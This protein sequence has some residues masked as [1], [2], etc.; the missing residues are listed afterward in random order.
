[1]AVFLSTFINKLDRKGRISVPATFRAALQD[2]SY[3]GIVVF[4]AVKHPAIE[5]AAMDRMEELS[6][7]IDQ[8]AEMSDER[9]ALSALLADARQLP[10][11]TEGRIMLPADLAKHA[12]IEGSAA[13][14]GRGPTFQLW[15]PEALKR[16][17]DEM[18]TRIRTLGLTLPPRET[19]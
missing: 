10:F 6:R 17:Q 8:L 7:R 4:R 5:A 11:D 18:R 2:S 14:V 3:A 12:G 1:V 9:D 19:P 16:H 13:F 15:E